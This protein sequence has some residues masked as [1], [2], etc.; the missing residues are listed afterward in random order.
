MSERNRLHD[1]RSQAWEAAKALVD[2]AEAESRDMTADEVEQFDRLSG[3][4]DSAGAQLRRLDVLD[5]QRSALDEWRGAAADGEPGVV[6]AES[7]W[8]RFLNGETRS[9]VVS[10]RAAIEGRALTS[11]GSPLVKDDLSGKLWVHLVA[12]AAM[13]DVA[14]VITTSTGAPMPVPTT[15]GDPSSAKVGE[16]QAITPSDP[17]V[18]PRS[19]GSFDYK[20]MSYVSTQ[21][22]Q[23]EAFDVAGLIALQAGRSVGNDLGA[24]LVAGG[25]T[26]EP[27]GIVG[28]STMGKTGAAGGAFTADDL[29][30]LFYSVAAPYRS[31]AGAAWLMS[32][33][34]AAAVRKL[35]NGAGDYLFAPAATVG[36]VD[37]FMGKPVV[38]DP[39]VPDVGAGAKSVLFGDLS[40]YYVRVV[41][42]LRF[43]RS[44]EFRF[45]TDEVAFRT[46]LSA[47]GTL[48]DR[49][50]AVKHFLGGS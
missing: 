27:D 34:T 1:E 18:A 39:N 31:G 8:R 30:D 47:D 14:T 3:V 37:R 43:E 33:T 9:Y 15:T 44:N 6:A 19:L 50:G 32:D 16:G 49:T 12:A 38:T 22:L 10:Q 24:D 23:D 35:K 5:R 29:V 7:E 40:A 2:A 36:E 11:V 28:L 20:S 25:G 46:V 41:D 17:Q 48:V 21:F 4:V 13:V 42:G 45:D 26:T